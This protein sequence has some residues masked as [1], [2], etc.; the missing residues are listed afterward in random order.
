MP[1]LNR[2]DVW[3]AI[4]ESLRELMEEQGQELGEVTR[5]MCLGADLGVSS[6]DSIHLIISLE[7][8]LQR[9]LSF[10]EMLMLP[11]GQPR[12]DMTL[13]E[14]LDFVASRTLPAEPAG[15]GD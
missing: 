8:R 5:D 14:L 9:P 11:D 12:K 2:E 1:E 7:D 4:V 10:E 13:G 3:D 15:A 6:I